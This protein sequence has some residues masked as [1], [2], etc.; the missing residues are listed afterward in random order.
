MDAHKVIGSV[1]ALAMLVGLGAAF[2]ARYWH[3][4][5]GE[6]AIE[7]VKADIEKIRITNELT[8]QRSKLSFL[9]NKQKVTPD[10]QLEMDWLR[11]QVRLLQ[12]QLV[13]LPKKQ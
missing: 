3:A 7:S 1:L 4:D 6:A 2:D 10:D 13:A 12:S 11:E 5:A 8:T 9:A